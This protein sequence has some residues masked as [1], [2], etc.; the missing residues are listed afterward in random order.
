MEL[1]PPFGPLALTAEIVWSQVVGTERGSDAQPRLRYQ[2]GLAFTGI[3]AEQQAVLG[4]ALARLIP[5]GGLGVGQ[6]LL[7]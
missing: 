6:I 7:G 2:S 5:G 3:T 4:K 1:P